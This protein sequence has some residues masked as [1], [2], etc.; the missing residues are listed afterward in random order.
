V[1]LEWKTG[2]VAWK[3]RG[4]FTSVLL[5]DGHLLC[6]HQSGHLSLIEANP[7]EYKEKHRFLPPDRSNLPPWTYPVLSGGKL[8]V[9]DQSFLLCYDLRA[10]R[11]RPVEPPSEKPAPEKPA[12][13]EREPDA[14]FVPSPQDVVERMLELA[15]IKKTDVVYD[16]GCGDGRIVVT[17]ARNY[18]CRAVGVDI[19]KE[20][21]KLAQENVLKNKVGEQVTIKHEDIFH[22]DVS[23]A[24]VVMLY[25]L[26][27][28]NEKLIPRLQS[29]KPGARIVSHSFP[30]PGIKP[31]K[32]TR[33]VSTEDD[34]SRP[35]YLFTAPLQKENKE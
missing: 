6:R 34:L 35:L 29:M 18:G 7:K 2:K 5:A 31:D 17:A 20:C 32:V 10:D 23:Q 11:P 15:E 21:V 13:K 4:T 24:D 27:N 1:C 22:I 28:V 25:L 9:R 30:I 3:E 33:Y 14:V 12:G 19:D 8:Y 26:P 16:L